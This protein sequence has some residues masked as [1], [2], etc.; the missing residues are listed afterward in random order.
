MDE[1]SFIYVG[2]NPWIIILK[3]RDTTVLEFL[4]FHLGLLRISTFLSYWI[5]DAL[6]PELIVAAD[7][8]IFVMTTRSLRTE[9]RNFQIQD[10]GDVDLL[11]HLI[12]DKKNNLIDEIF[13]LTLMLNIIG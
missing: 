6:V 11:P 9:T 12:L 7:A 4:S 8:L 2:A 3:S 10:G 13:S 5:Y 1:L